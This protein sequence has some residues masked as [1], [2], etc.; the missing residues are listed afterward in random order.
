MAE[1]I[2]YAELNSAGED[3]RRIKKLFSF[4]LNFTQPKKNVS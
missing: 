2:V 4:L 1:V 3:T